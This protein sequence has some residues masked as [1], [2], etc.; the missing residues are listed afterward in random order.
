M[1][2]RLNSTQEFR[3]PNN[4]AHSSTI[5]CEIT[6]LRPIVPQNA[7]GPI[8]S[9]RMRFLHSMI[10]LPEKSPSVQE[11]EKVA[12]ATEDVRH[13]FLMKNSTSIDGPSQ[14][15]K[16]ERS[17]FVKMMTLATAQEE[18]FLP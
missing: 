14:E 6:N 17:L 5:P 1:D 10:F 11:K 16:S 7:F 4:S 13:K 3:L 9:T 12:L 2:Q 8:S 15:T 18:N